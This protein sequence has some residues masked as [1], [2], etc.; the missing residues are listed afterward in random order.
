[1]SELRAVA[2]PRL[3]RPRAHLRQASVLVTS[4]S[5]PPRVGLGQSLSVSSCQCNCRTGS[6]SSIQPRPVSCGH[7]SPLPTPG[8]G[9]QLLAPDTGQMPSLTDEAHSLSVRGAFRRR[10]SQSIPTCPV[11]APK[12]RGHKN[13]Q[14]KRGVCTSGEEWPFREGLST[15]VS[16]QN[17]LG[18]KIQEPASRCL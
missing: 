7:S 8:T 14:S 6:Q 12:G 2:W 9:H 13:S 16:H 11:P 3:G 1:M 18:V 15:L 5:W 4:E 17:H 10:M